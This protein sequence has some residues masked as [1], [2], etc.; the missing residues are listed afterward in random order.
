[1]AAP[2]LE[3]PLRT[4]FDGWL[5]EACARCM[6]PL[7]FPEVRKG[8]RA[9][10]SLYVERRAGGHLASRALDGAGKRAAFSTCFA[11]VHFLTL[12]H[13]LRELDEGWA[14]DGTSRV[15]DLGAGTGAAGA[16]LATSLESP[17][18][19]IALDRSGWALGE[20]RRT[21]GAFGLAAR[22]VRGAL[23]RSLPRPRG[24]E[25]WVLGWCANE[26]DERA[27]QELLDALEAACQNGTKVLV[28]EP[29]AESAAPWWGEWTDRLSR[30]GVR[31]SIT[32][33][34]VE[35]PPW[36]QKLDRAAGLDHS[37]LGARLLWGPA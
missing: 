35:L 27:R 8:V 13:G 22:T 7:T 24:S 31:A 34:S 14:A 36:L 6:P 15:V 25:L 29:L 16:A 18:P 5:A 17:P 23:P 21:Y 11:P 10:S 19:L 1:V 33:A 37:E 20:A 3:E 9:L 4:A 2:Y 26:C 32:R 28:A 30:H 12:H